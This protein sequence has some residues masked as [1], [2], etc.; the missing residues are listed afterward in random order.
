MIFNLIN[1]AKHIFFNNSNSGLEANNVQDAIDELKSNLIKTKSVIIKTDMYGQA[2]V[3]LNE[4]DHIIGI[5]SCSSSY[6]VFPYRGNLAVESYISVRAYV[7]N[8]NTPVLAG[9]TE[10]ML[11]V[12]YC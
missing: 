6:G 7:T 12:I 1:K 9:N 2:N 5:I 3:G 11:L 10:I 8:G 4:G